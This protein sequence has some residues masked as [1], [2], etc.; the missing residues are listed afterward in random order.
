MTEQNLKNKTIKGVAWSGL[1]SVAQ[2]GVSFF[3]SIVL[4][5]LLSP[6]DY[7]LLGIIAIFTNVCNA[8]VNAGFSSALIRKYDATDD[9][10]NTVFLVNMVLSIVLYIL[11][12]FCSPLIAS[13]FGRVELIELTR[14]STI[15]IIISALAL[16]QQTRLTKSIDFKSQT[17][18]T[19]TS[20]ILSGIIGILMAFLGY[21]VWALVIQQIASALFRTI[22]LWAN[23]HWVPALKF[24]LKSFHELFGF[25]WKL[26]VSMLLDS[27]WK[28]MYQLVVGK[29]YNPATLGQ[30]TRAKNF[31]EMLSINLTT[32]VQRVTYPVMSTI[33]DERTRLTSAYRKLIKTTMYITFIAVFSL[34]SVSEPLLLCL[35]GEKWI[36]AAKYLPLICISGCLYPLQAINLNM[37]QVQGRSDLFLGLEVIKKI[38]IL[39]PLF[40]GAVIGIYEMLLTNIVVTIICFFLNSHYSGKL[41]NYSSWMQLKDITPS[42]MIA[43]IPAIAV[44]FLK[45]LPLSHWMI[46][47]IQIISLGIFIISLS[48]ITKSEEFAEIKSI[49]LSSFN[50]V[51][52]GIRKS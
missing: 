17:K 28:Q 47:P 16:V 51:K 7:G 11:I 45:F 49:A 22:F 12:Y 14:V 1:D 32:V 43:A 9:D 35:I 42:F 52:N 5:R 23:N 46:L 18:I 30:Y 24:S 2:F 19:F 4:A 36:E 37:L 29:F 31:S 26:M 25:G 8:L 20:S 44:Y 39:G 10:Y 34:A 15:T 38:I 41:I 3:I 50:K 21:G 6:D 27:V 13:F 48:I 40:I 33:Q